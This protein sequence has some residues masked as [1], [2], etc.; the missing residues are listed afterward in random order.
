[1]SAGPT[2]ASYMDV[3]WS[4]LP[5]P[6]DDGAA[7]HL[8][9]ARLPGVALAATDGTEVALARLPGRTVIFSYPKTGQPGTEM[10]E[11]WDAI[12]GARGCTP[13]T[14]AFRDH[15]AELIAA[16]ADRVFGLSTQDTVYQREAAQRLHL[17]FPLLSDA[18]LR[19]TTALRL[20]VMLVGGATLLKRMALIIEDG[21]VAHVFYPVF[22]PDQNAAEVLGW[23]RA[24]QE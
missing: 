16:G 22:P 11:G 10:P 9:G 3:D 20:P 12:P 24:R 1:M 6:E 15:H 23:L 4:S 14:C 13:Q 7:R 18:A 2:P 19:L 5:P 17:P 21:V 8:V